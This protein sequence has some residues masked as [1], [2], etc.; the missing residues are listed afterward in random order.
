MR[1][2]NY[3]KTGIPGVDTMLKGGLYP[4]SAVLVSGPPGSGKSI[5][6]MQ[7]I[8]S[9]L[10]DFD[11]QGLFVSVDETSGS[12]SDYAASIGW[13]DWEA[14]ANSGKITVIGA[15]YFMGSS[16]S[17]SLEGLMEAIG[18]TKARRMVIDPINL[19]KYYF[20]ADEDRRRYMLKFIRILKDMGITTLLVS[21]ALEQFPRMHLTEEMYLTD[22]NISLFLSRTGNTVERCFWATKMRCQEINMNI[23]PMSI[24]KGGIE[25]YEDSIPYSLVGRQGQDST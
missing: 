13:E 3:V 4:N 5:F 7:F 10:K 1:E 21:E 18:N 23:V 6:G 12:L 2:I 16:L 22:G 19:F 20:P 25:V 9:G 14:L 11:E 24:G 17:G 15:E 8:Y